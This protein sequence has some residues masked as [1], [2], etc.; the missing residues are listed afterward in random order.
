MEKELKDWLNIGRGS[1]AEVFEYGPGRVCKLFREGYPKEYVDLEYK[2]AEEIF[3]LGVRTPKPFET[4]VL[5]KRYGIVYERIE[6]KELL[7]LAIENEIDSEEMLDIL[8][9]LHCGLLQK[10]SNNVL[11]YKEFLTAMIKG[12]GDENQLLTDAINMLPDGDCVLHGDFYPSNVMIESDG[13]PV[14]I[15]FMNVCHGPA[16][17]DIARTFFLLRNNNETL[18]CS[19]LKKMHIY[20]EDIARY[21]SIIEECRRYEE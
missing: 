11:S 14:I 13:S 17:Y 1:T 20:R 15:D 12:K 4:I 6:G 19:Y 9:R 18:A 2:N 8:V 21:V 3:R 16:L 5:E 7:E 10:H